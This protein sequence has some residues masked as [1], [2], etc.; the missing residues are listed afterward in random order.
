MS[1]LMSPS[2]VKRTSPLALHMSGF[3]PKRTSLFFA[4]TQKTATGY[5][6]RWQAREV[7]HDFPGLQ[8]E[9]G[10]VPSDSSRADGWS[11]I[12]PRPRHQG[13]DKAVRKSV[14]NQ[15]LRIKNHFASLLILD[16]QPLRQ[17]FW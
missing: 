9:G 17:V 15:T 6:A 7:C 13:A 11:P 3:D 2:G 4:F 10:K 1:H 8:S 5:S 12:S 14:R 16:C